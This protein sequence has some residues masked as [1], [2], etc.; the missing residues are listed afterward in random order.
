MTRGQRVSPRILV[1]G[2]GSD[3][4]DDQVGWRVAQAVAAYCADPEAL[5]ARQARV[6]LDLLDWLQEF[7]IVHLCDAARWERRSREEFRSL[8]IREQQPENGRSPEESSEPQQSPPAGQISR[9]FRVCRFVWRNGSLVSDDATGDAGVQ[10]R[11]DDA[12]VRKDSSHGFGLLQVLQ[13]AEATGQL[14]DCVIVWTIAGT[15]FRPDDRISAEIDAEVHHAARLIV[16]S[17]PEQIRGMKSAGIGPVLA[18]GD[19]DA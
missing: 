7:D 10:I 18:R 6:P 9:K 1:A 13:L 15:C 4:G 12:D 17:L 16:T 3:H 2:I 5:T 11:V 8:M 19:F 14:P